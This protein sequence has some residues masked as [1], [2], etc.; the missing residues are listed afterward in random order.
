MIPT[1]ILYIAKTLIGLFFK[2]ATNF[3][4]TIS[5][6]IKDTINPTT[7]PII[8][9]KLSNAILIFT[10]F[11][12]DTPIITGNAKKKENSAAATVDNPAIHAPII[13]EA[14]LDIPG[15]IAKH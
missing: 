8:C 11:I 10:S 5:A 13:V 15:H 14:D 3:S 4:T 12:I 7:R 1:N 6:I 9:T 2:N